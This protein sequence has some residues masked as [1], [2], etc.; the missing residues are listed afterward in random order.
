MQISETIL[1]E[2]LKINNDG[3]ILCH[4]H[5]LSA[6]LRLSSDDFSCIWVS[7]DGLNHSHVHIIVCMMVYDHFEVLI[8]LSRELGKT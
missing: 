6:P 2:K 8:Q 1:V 7:Y 5:I 4:T 3:L